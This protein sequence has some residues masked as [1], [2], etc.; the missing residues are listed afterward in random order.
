[1]KLLKPS[2]EI[3]D[4]SNPYKLIEKCGRVCYKSES[5]IT[6]D[7]YVK[8][9]NMIKKNKH[10]SV[11]EHGTFYLT[12]PSGDLNFPRIR[13]GVTKLLDNKYTKYK[14]HNQLLYVTTNYRVIVENNLEALLFYNLGISEHHYKRTTVKFV[15]SRACAQQLT[16]HRIASFSMES[17][18]Y[19]N[20]SKGKFNGEISFIYLK[21]IPE[22][23]KNLYSECEKVYMQLIANK[24]LPQ[25]ARMV[26]PNATK[27]EL[28]MTAYNDDWQEI[29]NLRCS[30]S[31][32][33]EIRFLCNPLKDQI[34]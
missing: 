5:R 14:E 17:Q 6:N 33:E 16:R 22:V 9:I 4:N 28:I 31:A 25:E 26:L 27:T 21:D 24:F 20:Y 7:S 18:R 23:Q 3:L 13:E 10:L 32:D 30:N 11:L 12:I 29:F 1:M 34:K 15:C 2:V 19:C 8:F